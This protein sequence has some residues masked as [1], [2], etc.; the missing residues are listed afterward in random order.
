MTAIQLPRRRLLFLGCAACCVLSA[1]CALDFD[2]Y[3]PMDGGATDASTQT[4][5]GS[6]LGQQPEAEIETSAD[7][8]GTGGGDA[9][10]DT[11]PS[12]TDC[13]AV[14]QACD[15]EAGACGLACGVTSQQCQSQCPS[16]PCKTHCLQAEQTCRQGCE[17]TCTNCIRGAGCSGSAGCA[18]AAFAD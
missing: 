6:D 1:A 15:E 2:K 11:G 14:S 17:S 8:P 13:G 7:S 18:D 5:A 12:G 3:G 9:A 16:N 10:A 4:D